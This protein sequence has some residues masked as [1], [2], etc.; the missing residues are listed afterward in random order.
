VNRDQQNATL[1]AYDLA[2]LIQKAIGHACH[3]SRYGGPGPTV[4]EDLDRAHDAIAELVRVLEPPPATRRK[5]AKIDR[6]T[7]RGRNPTG[8]ES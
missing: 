5:R 4:R 3:V 2:V 6:V 8:E 7:G 1:Y